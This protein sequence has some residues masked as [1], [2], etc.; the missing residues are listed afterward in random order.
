[1]RITTSSPKTHT[2]LV[3]DSVFH[4]IKD[5]FH[6][7]VQYTTHSHYIQIH[8]S[9][10]ELLYMYQSH[11][12][13]LGPF[14]H[15]PRNKRQCVEH[16]TRFANKVHKL[17]LFLTVMHFSWHIGF[18]NAALRVYVFK[19]KGGIVGHNFVQSIVRKSV[20]SGD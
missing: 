13:K 11:E 7:L 17:S 15:V 1:M 4:M 12:V 18:K 6:K 5:L 20:R 16:K 9:Y 19:E 14:T 3:L 8:N 10:F 2:I